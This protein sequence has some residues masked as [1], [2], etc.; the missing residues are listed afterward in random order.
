M[1]AAQGELWRC[2]V[3]EERGAG[4]GTG[5]RSGKQVV[6]AVTGV[7]FSDRFGLVLSGP[8]TGLVGS[9]FGTVRKEGQNDCRLLVQVKGKVGLSK[10][11]SSY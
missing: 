9:T 8:N 6:V 2:P 4:T 7:R 11:R 1:L 10:F 3:K 5:P